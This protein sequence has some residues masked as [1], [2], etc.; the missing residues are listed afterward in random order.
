MSGTSGWVKIAVSGRPSTSSVIPTW[1]TCGSAD[2]D[3]SATRCK[4]ALN[5]AS[6][7]K[8]CDN[9]ET[10]SCSNDPWPLSLI[11]FLPAGAVGRQPNVLQASDGQQASPATLG[12]CVSVCRHRPRVRA[13]AADVGVAGADEPSGVG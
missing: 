3:S 2:I 4:V 11:A 5:V 1:V 8:Y 12:V 10:A 9:D 13:G 6:P 7:T